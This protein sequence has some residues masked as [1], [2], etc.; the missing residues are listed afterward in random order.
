M[1]QVAVVSHA[2]KR[3][4]PFG[5]AQWSLGGCRCVVQ[6]LEMRFTNWEE[7]GFSDQESHPAI[8]NYE[9]CEVISIGSVSGQLY[10]FID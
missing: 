3:T 8:R 5:P 9:G 6:V 7:S 4:Y 1:F 2:D 10:R